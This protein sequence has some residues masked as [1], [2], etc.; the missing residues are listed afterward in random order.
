MLLSSVSCV[1]VRR[2]DRLTKCSF[3]LVIDK[4]VL[5][6]HPCCVNMLCLRCCTAVMDTM[7]A[8]D[9]GPETVTAL[10]SNVYNL[11]RPG[12]AYFL[13]SHGSPEVRLPLLNSLPG[14]VWIVTT[15]TLRAWIS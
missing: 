9:A 4:G 6:F 8:T 7:L 1:D 14:V 5:R 2:L 13:V 10:L 3:D 15:A 11:L 12:G